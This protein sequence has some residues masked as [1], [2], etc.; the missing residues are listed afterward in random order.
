MKLNL[1]GHDERYTVEQSLMNLLPG[2]LPVYEP[3]L[4]E[5]DTWGVIA[6][7]EDTLCRVSV[8]LCVK[9]KQAKKELSAASPARI[10]KKKASAGI[11]WPGPFTLL[12]A[13]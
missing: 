6:L 13:R 8:E 4:P 9:G 7:E 12:P 2:E 5:D 3:I 11:S 1:I 10:M